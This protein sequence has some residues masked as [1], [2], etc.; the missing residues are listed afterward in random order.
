MHIRDTTFDAVSRIK[1][2][3]EREEGKYFVGTTWMT[4]HR[5]VGRP[6]AGAARR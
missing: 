5:M 3:A 6:E 4:K 1:V 2:L